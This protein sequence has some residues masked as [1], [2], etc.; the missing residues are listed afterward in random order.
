MTTV[1]LP[2]VWPEGQKLQRW[3]DP[4]V[5]VTS[6]EDHAQYHGALIEA[7]LRMEQNPKFAR[8][9]GGD[10]GIGRAKVFDLPAWGVPEATLIHERAL[11]MFRR[12]FNASEVHVDLSWS[13]IYGPGDSCLPHSHPRTYAGVVY[14]LEP[15]NPP[16]PHS[17]MFIF[18]DPRMP[19]C[20]RE[21]PGYMSTPCAP[22]MPAGTMI[23]FPGQL[24]HAVSTYRGTEPRITLSWNLNLKPV[25]GE[26]L[27]PEHKPPGQF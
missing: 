6:F 8:A 25:E 17:G 14:M 24:V 20:C 22:L 5:A 23:M 12:A 7:V 15:G 26:A 1:A 19:V 18:A 27:R 21:Q 9:Y 3:R 4:N 2:D 16:D 11:S 13:S 10:D